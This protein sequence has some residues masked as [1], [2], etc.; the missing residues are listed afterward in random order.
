MKIDS[1]KSIRII[2]NFLTPES[3]NKTAFLDNH[4]LE[5]DENGKI[6]EF[7]SAPRL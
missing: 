5:T 6:T 2:S 7:H 4:I 3:Y 1:N